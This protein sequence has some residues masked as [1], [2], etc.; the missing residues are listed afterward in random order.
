MGQLIL[1]LGQLILSLGQLILSLGLLI[2]SFHPSNKVC[3]ITLLQELVHAGDYE[4]ICVCETWLNKT[5]LD[6]ELLPGFNIF[7]KDRNGKIGGGVLIAV[8]EGLQATRRCD[9]ERD[10]AEFVVVQINKVN[11]SSV[12]LYTYYRPPQTY[13]DSLKLLNNS[14]LS[15]PESS[16]IVLIGDF[17]LPN[18][19][20]WPDNQ[21]TIPISY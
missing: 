3:K 17:N 8:K 9:L 15:N 12:I 19:I 2:L 14:L 10:G 1:S 21:S 11:N 5:V 6:S 4:V 20:S 18:Y 13:S 7:R 16:C